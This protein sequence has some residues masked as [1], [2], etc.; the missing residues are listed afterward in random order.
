MLTHIPVPWLLLSVEC[1][2]HTCRLQ[3][4]SGGLNQDG[5]RC[6]GMGWELALGCHFPCSTSLRAEGRPWLLLPER[7]AAVRD[8][9]GRPD[10]QR[11]LSAGQPVPNAHRGGQPHLPGGRH[12][13]LDS[14]LLPRLAQF[15]LRF[16]LWRHLCVYDDN[17]LL[18]LCPP[19]TVPALCR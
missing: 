4:A 9:P 10:W 13:C 2:L 5:S 1:L 11:Q 12:R 8:V 3:D 16:H 17:Q 6:L 15:A 14:P 18:H 7:A 19:G